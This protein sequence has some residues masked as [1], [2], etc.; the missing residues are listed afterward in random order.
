MASAHGLYGDGSPEPERAAT[1]T[2]LQVDGRLANPSPRPE[3][4]ENNRAI[5]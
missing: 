3:P 1:R 4:R 2:K 5:A